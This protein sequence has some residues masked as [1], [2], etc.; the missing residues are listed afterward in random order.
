MDSVERTIEKIKQ[1][2]L[3]E[4]KYIVQK[5]QK[6]IFKY[7]YHMLGAMEEAEDAVQEVFIK[8]YQRLYHYKAGTSFSSWLYKIA[9]NHCIDHLRRKRYFQLV[10]LCD[11]V[12]DGCD[13]SYSFEEDELSLPLQRAISMLP[14]EDRT[15]LM[16]R[17]LEEKSYEEIADV[18]GKRS[19]T[20]RKRYERARKKIKQSISK[21]EGDVIDG[22]FAVNQ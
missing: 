16:L 10:P 1:G 4:Y 2:S 12:V 18:L 11:S 17:I 5:Y 6:S 21:M 7:C 3:E 22:K 8:A 15:V 9:Y 14:P 20:V 19:S 13:V